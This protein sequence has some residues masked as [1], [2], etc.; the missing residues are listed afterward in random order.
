MFESISNF[1]GQAKSFFSHGY[2]VVHDAVIGAGE[3]ISKTVHSVVDTPVSVVKTVYGDAKKVVSN[4]G[5]TIAHIVDRSQ[6]SVDKVIGGGERV[7]TN[8]QNVIGDTTKGL[9]QSLSM[10]LVLGGLGAL[11]LIMQKK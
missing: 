9:G 6:D 1:F 8:A 2:D 10:P 11:F 4:I 7:L 5:N 3:S